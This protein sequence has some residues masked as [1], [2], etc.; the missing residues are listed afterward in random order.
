MEEDAESSGNKNINWTE[1]AEDCY[2]QGLASGI[3]YET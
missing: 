2:R 3:R 1:K